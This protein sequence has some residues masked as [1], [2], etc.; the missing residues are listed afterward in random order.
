LSK[1]FKTPGRVRLQGMVEGFNILNTKNLTNYNGVVTATTY[2]QPASS[3]DGFYQP[4][5]LQFAFRVTY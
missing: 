1:I 2:L 3:T 5:Q 4:R